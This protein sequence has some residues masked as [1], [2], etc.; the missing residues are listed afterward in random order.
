MIRR[1][2]HT[3]KKIIFGKVSEKEALKGCKLAE[4]DT[5]FLPQGHPWIVET[6]DGVPTT[7]INSTGG[8]I[9]FIQGNDCFTY[10]EDN[11]KSLNEQIQKTFKANVSELPDGNYRYVI[12]EYDNSGS[13]LPH[14][15]IFSLLAFVTLK[16][17]LSNLDK[18][19]ILGAL[20]TK[21]VLGPIAVFAGL[22]G[23]GIAF[24]ESNEGE[25]LI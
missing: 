14:I 17:P 5:E 12:D 13:I 3:I 20:Q 1:D 18:S 11:T 16:R 4:I 23:M 6:R 9:I 10:D 22:I 8:E 25:E 24:R 21:E 19:D 15:F 7:F 2:I